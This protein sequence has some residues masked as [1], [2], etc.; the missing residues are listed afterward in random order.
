MLTMFKSSL[1]DGSETLITL[2]RIIICD[3]KT[4]LPRIDA[5]HRSVPTFIDLSL[6]VSLGKLNEI[7]K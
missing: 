1:I 5:Y 3:T 6:S 4:T 2:P 7:W